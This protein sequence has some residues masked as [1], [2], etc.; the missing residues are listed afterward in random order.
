M[1]VDEFIAISHYTALAPLPEKAYPF[2]DIVI[3][4]VNIFAGPRGYAVVKSRINKNKNK[5]RIKK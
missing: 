2:I 4:D 5:T 3:A 1:G